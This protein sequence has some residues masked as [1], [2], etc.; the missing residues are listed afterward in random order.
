LRPP[1]G[2]TRLESRVNPTN[3]LQYHMDTLSTGL[4]NSETVLTR[5]NVNATSFGKLWSVQVQGQVYAEPVVLTGVNITA[6]ANQGMHN[7]VFVATEHDQLY[8]FDADA[9]SP[10]L[11]WQRSFLSDA[12]NT[13]PGDLLAGNTGVIPVPQGDIISS[14]I[15]VEIGITGTP[16]IDPSTGTIYLIAKTKETVSG[17]AHYVQRL[18]AVNVQNGTDRTAP[19]LLGDTVGTG[20][21]T[22]YASE[23]KNSSTA[24]SQ[25]WVY[26]NGNS[27]EAITD[28]YFGTGRNIVSFNALREAQRPGLTLANGVV[29]MAW[30]SHGDNGPYHGWVVGVSAYSAGSPNLTLKGVLNTTP[31]S[32]LGGIW[33]AGG[34]IT[35]DGTYLYLETGNG[36]FDGNN[37]TGTGSNPTAPA[38]GPITGIDNA[39]FPINGDYGDSFI[40]IGLDSTTAST[41]HRTLGTATQTD[42]SNGWGMAVVDYFTPFNQAWLNA[43]DEDVGSSATVIVPD[44]DPSGPANQFASAATPH[45]LV[46]SGKEGV[47]YLMNRDNMGKYGLKN[48]IVQNTANQ[49]SGSLDSAAFFNGQMYYVEGY[50]GVA[51]SF[52]FAN[53]SFSLTPTTKSADAFQ[54][55][56]STPF[57][58]ANNGSDGIVWDVDRGTNQLRAYSSDSYATE[59]Y[60]SSQAPGGR[61]AMGAAVTFQVVTVANGRVFVGAGTGDPNNVLDVYGL[62]APPTNVPND[63]SGLIAQAISPTQISLAWTDNSVAPNYAD[64]FSIEE[65][66]NGSTNWT[67]FATVSGTNAG[68]LA[69]GL[70]AG[71]TYYFRVRAHNSFGYSGYTNVS[72]ATTPAAGPHSIDY[73]SGFT[74]ANTTPTASQG[75]LTFNGGT[76]AQLVPGNGRLQ[77][78]SGVNGQD[79]SAYYTNPQ[80]DPAH[81]GKQYIVGFSTTF[82]YNMSGGAGNPADGITFVIQNSG[83]TALGG[84]GGGLGYAGITPS[85][86]FSINLYSGHPLGTEFLTNGNV[87]ELFSEQNI[88]VQL[89]NT[90][91]TV[92]IGYAAGVVTAQV[93]QTINGTVETDTK[94]M[95]V[96]IPA[97][98]GSNYAY[99]GF[100]GATG[101][102]NSTQEITYWTFDQGLVPA[103]PTNLA[104]AV[105]GF[106]GASNNAVPLGAHLTWNAVTDTPPAGGTVSYKILRKLTTGGTYQQIGTSATNS[107]DDS[108]LTT[109]STYYYE[110]QATDSFGDSLPSAAAS[111]TTP[112]LPPTPTNSQ[113]NSVTDTSISF[114]WQDNANNE[115]GYLILRATNGGTFSINANLPPDTNPAP[116]TMTYTDTGLT[117]GT[118]YDYHVESYNLAGYS[119]FVG[120]TTTTTATPP[121]G[122]AATTTSTGISLTWNAYAGAT[123]YNV[124]RGTSMN[125]EGA[126]PIA[127]GITSPN[128]TDASLTYNT[129]Y[130]YKVTAVD[131][132]GE[133]P[134]S[135][136]SSAFFAAPPTVASVQVNDGS[137]QRSEVRSITV[138]FSGPVNFAGGNANAAAAFQLLHIQNNIP[139]GLSVAISTDGMGRTV[140][141]LTFAG[142]ETDQISALNGFSQNPSLVDGRYRL[143]IVG[144]SI[145]SSNG[146]DLDGAGTGSPGSN[147]ISPTDTYLGSGLHLYRLFGDV[148]G[149]GVVDA[150]DVGQL[151]STFNRNSSDPLYISFLDADNNGVVDASDVGQF[152]PRFNVNVF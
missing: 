130:Y 112:V 90:P 123:S 109:G 99:V 47:I 82:T 124:Y 87:D 52:A 77:L 67:Q 74:T 15:T 46:G 13:N 78:T 64:I 151:K 68:Y 133:S 147:Y 41:Q 141:T 57:I 7:V 42:H 21:Y 107:F 5:S 143:T 96:N 118:T 105:T 134:K 131:T 63:P 11:L 121:T 146:L 81:Q 4:N 17:T 25:I 93:Q 39:G 16:V 34:E 122:L 72:G 79:R 48:N 152:K 50:G 43:T 59:L 148:S 55:A 135:N 58:T 113:L 127:T 150:T 76:Q 145:S 33:M 80:A 24:G 91:I 8:A 103:A 117:R 108:G 37:G 92:T 142:S 40:K 138:T 10:V 45:L 32:G 53:G 126:T 106:T 20:P 36:G 3:V 102:A 144:Q 51:K 1:L 38:P 31:N 27:G 125:G 88:N 22:N 89:Q 49:L 94:S 66:P 14:N 84:A 23:A 128:Y 86:A 101:G 44:Y 26:G 115:N 2:V 98:I 120:V 70:T 65:S 137:I 100:T 73:S 60:N 9:N 85:F 136:E 54:Y 6:G 132:G 97:L 95:A 149:D 104:A 75:G 119:D 71:A 56:G 19:F 110:V 116:S 28:P 114:Q 111:I 12:N 129:T 29:Y 62:L 61:D 139:V 35:F 18:Y 83:L 140:A 69:T 30:A